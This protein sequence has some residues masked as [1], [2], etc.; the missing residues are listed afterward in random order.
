M[1][2]PIPNS[3]WVEHGRFAAGEYP[4]DK[5]PTGAE[6]KLRTLLAAGI[7]TFVDLTEPDEGLE[8]YAPIL[9][10]L[11]QE[12]GISVSHQRFPIHDFGVPRNRG[13]MSSILDAVDAARSDGGTV[14]LHCWGG[15]GRTGTVVGCW[16]VRRGLSGIDALARLAELWQGV[17]KAYRIRHSPETPAQADYIRYWQE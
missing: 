12:R 10:Q 8:P 16:L 3:Y 5:N 11:G 6:L 4:G 14:Y 7:D 2:R 9:I 17:E 13:H 1:E 15:V